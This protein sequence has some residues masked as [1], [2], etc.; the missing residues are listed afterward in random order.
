M[1]TRLWF[2]QPHTSKSNGGKQ[3]VDSYRKT[4]SKTTK[5]GHNNYPG[6]QKVNTRKGR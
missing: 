2:S 5:T 6:K 1:A 4:G 3:H